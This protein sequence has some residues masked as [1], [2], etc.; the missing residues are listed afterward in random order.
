MQIEK[1]QIKIFNNKERKILKCIRLN[2]SM[3]S[4]K[5]WAEIMYTRDITPDYYPQYK[6]TLTDL[7]LYSNTERILPQDAFDDLIL[8]AVQ[9]KYPDVEMKSQDIYSD[10]CAE[11]QKLIYQSYHK[12]QATVYLNPDLSDIDPAFISSDTV[13]TRYQLDVDIYIPINTFVPYFRNE[14]YFDYYNLKDKEKLD[15][16]LEK[17]LPTLHH[18][19]EM[20]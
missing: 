3:G 1:T 19:E 4:F 15:S 14:G 17:S 12:E 20:W 2:Q 8:K 11:C 9:T 6:K 10:S 5:A 13:F 18:I 7:G 16:I